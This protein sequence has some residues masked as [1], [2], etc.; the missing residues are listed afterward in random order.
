LGR[1]PLGTIP[2]YRVDPRSAQATGAVTHHHNGFGCPPRRRYPLRRPWRREGLPWFCQIKADQARQ[3][4]FHAGELARPLEGSGMVCSFFHPGLVASGFNRNNG[5]LMSLAMTL[6]RPVS[7]SVEKGAET[8]VWLTRASNVGM[9]GGYFGD[10]ERRR[11]SPQAQDAQTAQR[12]WEISER[13]C[14]RHWP[15]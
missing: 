15:S 5:P 3:H 2:L 4:L 12:L 1:Q 10:M 7:R 6:L 8:L 13:Q 9:N 11:P 14:G